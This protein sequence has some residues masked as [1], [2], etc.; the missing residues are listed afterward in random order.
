MINQPGSYNDTL[1]Y[2]SLDS[3]ITL[4]VA[5]KVINTVINSLTDTVCANTPFDL[6]A[7]TSPSYCTPIVQNLDTTYYIKYQTLE[8]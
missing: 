5:Y 6:L 4:N 8:S 1:F 7:Q 2:Y 3:I